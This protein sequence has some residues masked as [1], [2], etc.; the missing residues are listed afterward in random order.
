MTHTPYCGHL[1]RYFQIHCIQNYQFVEMNIN[2]LLAQVWIMMMSA[3]NHPMV[4]HCDDGLVS[5]S[6]LPPA[7]AQLKD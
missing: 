3:R 5:T 2:L 1:Q 7:Y 4:I 6:Q